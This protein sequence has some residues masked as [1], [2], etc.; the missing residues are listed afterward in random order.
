[1]I[2]EEVSVV[3]SKTAA[4]N[5]EVLSKVLNNACKDTVLI[6]ELSNAEVSIGE[7]IAALLKEPELASKLHQGIIE[8]ISFIDQKSYVKHFGKH[9]DEIAQVFDQAVYTMEKY[10][11]DAN[12]VIRE[13]IF[14]P[15][16]NAYVKF[17]GKATN[18]KFIDL[19][20]NVSKKIK[21]AMVGLDRK[22]GKITTFHI[23]KLPELIKDAPSL[24]LELKKFKVK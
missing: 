1:M 17:I 6:S 4:V 24:G 2:A 20:E 13:G 9:H 8:E 15:E 3:L 11:N 12:H 19:E 5:P 23:K 18:K 16:K 14:I 21:Y 10:L 22:T 7:G